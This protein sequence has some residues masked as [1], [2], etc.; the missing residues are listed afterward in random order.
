[1]Y[2][3]G[4]DVAQDYVKTTHWT[5]KA[6]NQGNPAAQNNLGVMFRMG[7]GVAQNHKKAVLWFRKA[8]DQGNTR[9]QY[10]LS[11]Y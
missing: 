1:M 11:L 2:Q 4:E 3:N 5:R 8:A 9:T 7:Q 10:N 6:A